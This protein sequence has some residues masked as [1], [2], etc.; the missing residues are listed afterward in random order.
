M[1]SR[2]VAPVVDDGPT[3]AQHWVS[4]SCLFWRRPVTMSKV[5]SHQETHTRRRPIY[6]PSGNIREV[7]PTSRRIFSDASA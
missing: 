6:E 4:V 1:V 7:S 3:L 2:C 5:W